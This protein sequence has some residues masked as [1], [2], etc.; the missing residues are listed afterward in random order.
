MM[1]E[2]FIRNSS[3]LPR[4][5]HSEKLKEK[6]NFRAILVL[7]RTK[8][9]ICEVQKQL[10]F[11]SSHKGIICQPSIVSVCKKP[12][13]EKDQGYFS[14]NRITRKRILINSAQLQYWAA[15]S[16]HFLNGIKGG[17][18]KPEFDFTK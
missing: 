14:R 2:K 9:N 1:A 4:N 17:E 7:V 8:N 3:K 16:T 11:S 15:C 10:L 13:W 12:G 5:F 18:T 6:L